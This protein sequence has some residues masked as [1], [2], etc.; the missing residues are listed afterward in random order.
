MEPLTTALLIGGVSMAANAFAAYQKGEISAEEYR[1]AVAAANELEQRLKTLRPDETWQD[2]KPELL[3]KAAEFVPDI[4]NFVQENAPQLITEAGAAAEKRIQRQALQKYAAQAE[5]GRDVISE[6]QREQALFEADAR[7]KQRQQALMEKMRQQGMLGSGAALAAQMQT[8]QATAQEARQASLQG[9]QEAE[10][11]RRQALGEAAQL[12][13]Q[14]RQANVNVE[15]ANVQTMNAFNQRLANARNLYNQ[16]ASGQ[17]NQSQMENQR[18]EM[19]RQAANLQTANQYALMNRQQALAARE[20]ARQFDYDVANRMFDI[21]RGAEAGKYGAER[22]KLADYTTAFT[23]GIGT[24]LAAYGGLSS[25]AAKTA[26]QAAAQGAAQGLT[27]AA[28]RQAYLAPT[29]PEDIEVTSNYAS[30][31]PQTRLG[32]TNVSDIEMGS[33]YGAPPQ[34]YDWRNE[35]VI[36]DEYGN[37]DWRAMKARA[38]RNQGV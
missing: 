5:T 15:S 2:I 6:A 34:Q 27:S 7:A 8:E 25:A 30:R 23:G 13:G 4:A 22:Q 3:Q 29:A 16:Y 17:R 12:A 31:P 28:T 14:L 10:M 21:R 20:R 19:A 38:K 18:R 9:A 24:G 36:Y 33:N 37:E 1:Q 35:P 11:R 32:A 26:A